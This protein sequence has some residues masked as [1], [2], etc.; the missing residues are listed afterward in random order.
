[1]TATTAAV[2]T[3][4]MTA[5]VSTM[6]TA[7]AVPIGRD[8]ATFFGARSGTWSS[9]ARAAAP[10][11]LHQN[12][13]R[14]HGSHATGT[15]WSRTGTALLQL[16]LHFFR[17]NFK[18]V[19]LILWHFVEFAICTFENGHSELLQ[20]QVS[21]RNQSQLFRSPQQRLFQDPLKMTGC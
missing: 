13:R 14:P 17:R 3:T 12:L 16:R 8:F 10:I 2:M 20:F 5:T 21:E 15:A 1:M 4:V 11:N 6:A 9:A 19:E 18:A 7:A